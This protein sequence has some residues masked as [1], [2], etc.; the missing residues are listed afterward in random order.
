MILQK[1]AKCSSSSN[2]TMWSRF[3]RISHS[4]F[5]VFVS[6]TSNSM[7]TFS[8]GLF[9]VLY[10]RG[11]VGLLYTVVRCLIVVVVEVGY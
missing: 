10:L 8:V 5:S 9:N 6:V 3:R 11:F 4:V 2:S 1:S 7:V